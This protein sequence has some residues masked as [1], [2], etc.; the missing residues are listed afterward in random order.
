MRQIE[1]YYLVRTARFEPHFDHLPSEEE[2]VM[3]QEM[4]WWTNA[5]IL[6]SDA[7]FVPRDLAARLGHL[8]AA[9][10]PSEPVRLGL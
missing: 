10:I 3:L 2:R 9:G 7:T 1:S 6:A 8:A 5:E 4:R